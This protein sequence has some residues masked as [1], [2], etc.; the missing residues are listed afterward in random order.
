MSILVYWY[1][2][3]LVC[4]NTDSLVHRCVCFLDLVLNVIMS[5]RRS[6]NV[7]INTSIAVSTTHNRIRWSI[8]W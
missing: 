1:V 6:I 2:G 7:G 8:K 4:E 5:T 3:T